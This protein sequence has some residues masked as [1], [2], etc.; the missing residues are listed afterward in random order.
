MARGITRGIMAFQTTTRTPIGE[1]LFKLTFGTKAVIPI[2]VGL[3]SL[4]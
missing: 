2:E 4:K 3:S 1:T